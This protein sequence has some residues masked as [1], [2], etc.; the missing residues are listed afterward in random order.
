MINNG[1][2]FVPQASD[3]EIRSVVHG[4][5]QD[6]DPQLLIKPS[7]G[8]TDVSDY[9]IDTFIIDL[10]KF[11]E[12][13]Q[14][15]TDSFKDFSFRPTS[16]YESLSEDEGNHLRHRIFHRKPTS[17]YNFDCVFDDI[18]YPGYKA[19]VYRRQ[20]ETMFD[21]YSCSRN[22]RDA[23]KAAYEIESILD[24]HRKYFRK[25][26]LNSLF[27]VERRADEF[28]DVQSIMQYQIPLVFTAITNQYKIVYEK[29]L[30]SLAIELVLNK[31][32]KAN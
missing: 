9:D 8:F 25:K 11:F 28:R 17:R 20:V 29:T 4:F 1:N 19:L 31:T 30:E 3:P 22:Y 27:Y 7:Q 10:Y 12:L 5:V 6:I 16:V 32:T 21:I 2:L 24:I 14:K 15:E 26:G 23:D 13:Y 18:R